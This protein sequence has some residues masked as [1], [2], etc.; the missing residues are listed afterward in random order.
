MGGSD[1]PSDERW[2]ASVDG[3][4]SAG[5]SAS[6]MAC[7]A[8]GTQAI[9]K[10]VEKAM[11]CKGRVGLRYTD[12]MAGGRTVGE[13]LMR[14]EGYEDGRAAE[15]CRGIGDGRGRRQTDSKEGRVG[16]WRQ[17]P[18]NPKMKKMK[19]NEGYKTKN[20]NINEIERAVKICVVH[21][22]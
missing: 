15:E 10:P 5:R 11:A 9:E 1:M 17:N 22:Q 2:A 6:R 19:K 14:V 18:Q 12:G 16:E 7:S 3:V 4:T 21:M 20:I 8:A 13:V